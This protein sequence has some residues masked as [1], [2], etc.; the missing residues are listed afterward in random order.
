MRQAKPLSPAHN[1]I[2]TMLLE[3]DGAFV[4]GALLCAGA[5]IPM[6][7][8]SGWMRQIREARPDLLIESKHGSG[9]RVANVAAPE[10]VAPT[11]ATMPGYRGGAGPAVPLHRR[12]AASMAVLDLLAPKTAE[13]VK[14]A[15]IDSCEDIDATLH[16]LISYGVEVHNDLVLAG[17]NPV[18]L[19]RP[20]AGSGNGQ[21]WQ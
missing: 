2:V 21:V 12:M 4:R 11:I 14:L 15:A 13:L 20:K 3:A 1:R 17:E 6:D 19:R 9:Y 18:G 5:G 16:R 10:A 8:L 7:L